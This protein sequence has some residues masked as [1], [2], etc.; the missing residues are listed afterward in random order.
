MSA[1][2]L[3]YIVLLVNSFRIKHFHHKFMV[4]ALPI[5]LIIVYHCL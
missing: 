5:L 4:Y 2:Y 1:I 3:L